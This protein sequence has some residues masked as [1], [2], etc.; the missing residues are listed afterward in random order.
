MYIY[1]YSSTCRKLYYNK[2]IYIYIY[3]DM[4]TRTPTQFGL[5]SGGCLLS[6]YVK[7]SADSAQ[8]QMR[9]PA[10]YGLLSPRRY[11]NQDRVNS[12][13]SN[14]G[15][16]I[17]RI[18][19]LGHVVVSPFVYFCQGS[20]KLQLQGYTRVPC[21]LTQP[22]HKSDA[23]CSSKT[24]FFQQPSTVA[25]EVY[26]GPC[27]LTGLV[28]LYAERTGYG[29]TRPENPKRKKHAKNQRHQCSN[30]LRPKWRSTSGRPHTEK[31]T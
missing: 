18:G 30:A 7:S 21:F 14:I 22:V 1:I 20:S 13:Y 2:C 31:R 19:G 28:N 25:Y 11:S 6:C 23:E 24:C 3:M 29:N 15:A 4:C 9:A 10:I 12:S 5:K 26:W 16:S 27:R 8:A 17:V